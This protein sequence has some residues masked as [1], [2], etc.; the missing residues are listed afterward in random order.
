[1]KAHERQ[2]RTG[3][4]RPTVSGINRGDLFFLSKF[5]FYFAVTYLSTVRVFRLT[6]PYESL[7]WKAFTIGYLKMLHQLETLV[8][9]QNLHCEVA[10]CKVKVHFAVEETMKAQKGGV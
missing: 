2:S 9:L 5:G 6:I 1:M 8:A 4:P 3:R 7:C 10:S